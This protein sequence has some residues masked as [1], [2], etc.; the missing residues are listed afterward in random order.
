[1]AKSNEGEGNTTSVKAYDK[2]DNYDE[3]VSGHK[4]IEQFP[5]EQES[6]HT[7]GLVARS[8]EELQEHV[9]NAHREE[10]TG[11][12]YRLPQSEERGERTETS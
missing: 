2:D 8:K 12:N 7:C 4:S 3:I 10:T 6:C 11:E 9:R 1:M 5:T